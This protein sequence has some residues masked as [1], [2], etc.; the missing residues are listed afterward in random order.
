L[1]GNQINDISPLVNLTDLRVLYLNDNRIQDISPLATLSKIGE[2]GPKFPK[3]SPHL[4]LS[5]NQISDISSLVSNSGIGE[6]DRVNLK[7]NPLND[8]AYDVHIP[9]L[10]ERGVKVWFDP[11]Q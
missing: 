2:A 8:E 5:N 10:Q 1:Y 7:G 9:A 3:S 11:K 4:T 6:E